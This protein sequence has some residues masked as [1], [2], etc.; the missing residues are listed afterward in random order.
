MALSTPALLAT[1]TP[2]TTASITSPSFTPTANS[3]ILVVSTNTGSASANASYTVTDSLG[4]H[5]TYTLIAEDAGGN[6]Q[7]GI[8]VWWATSA[9]PASMTVTATSPGAPTH[10]RLYVYEYTG[11]DTTTPIVGAAHSNGTTSTTPQVTT[12]TSPATGDHV[13][14]W[15][16]VR[17]VNASPTLDSN[18]TQIA[19]AHNVSPSATTQG[20]YR[21]GTTSGVTAPTGMGTQY[22]GEVAFVVQA[23]SGSTPISLSDTGTG[24]DA[25]SAAVTA[26]L[27]DVASGDGVLTVAATLAASDA[28]AA[29]V[30]ALTVA[31]SIPL[32]DARPAVTDALAVTATINL[33][34]TGTGTDAIN[35]NTG[36]TPVSQSDSVSGDGVLTASV[37][38]A[39]ADTVSAVEG[40]VVNILSTLYQFVSP[41]YVQGP[42]GDDRF[43]KRLAV[44]HSTSILKYGSSYV[45]VESPTNEQIVAA[46]VTYLGGHV[47]TVGQTEADALTA[48]GYGGGLT[49]I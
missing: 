39:V 6:T 43:W 20:G 13:N 40:F 28:S 16:C 15:V 44:R 49:P 19:E 29:T 32:A 2:V 34:D 26:P 27:S 17:N 5:L 10:N 42:A 24:A 48:A 4:S 18:F 11:H 31:P 45:P 46:D 14:Y 21:T 8:R 33:T 7:G 30:D 1:A 22:N 37:T 47:Y 23:S 35:V 9:S 36:T 12:A 25:L 38:T 3:L 41:L